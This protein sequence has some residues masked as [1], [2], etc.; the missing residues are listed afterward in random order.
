MRH[1]VPGSCLQL[2]EWPRKRVCQST[3][4]C[5][6]MTVRPRPRLF[7]GLSCFGK[8]GASLSIY[9]ALWST[10]RVDGACLGRWVKI[11][12]RSCLSRLY[13]R[14]WASPSH[15]A[16]PGS[17]G[18]EN[19]GRACS[20]SLLYSSHHT[21][22][23]LKGGPSRGAVFAMRPSSTLLP[24]VSQNEEMRAHFYLVMTLGP[25]RARERR[26]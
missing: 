22:I 1:K 9:S 17:E 24:H 21:P 18:Q 15:K 25:R 26:L 4:W 7:L 20:H 19:Q 12:R 5:R 16:R 13:R 2:G 23:P 8:R 6:E 14:P 10:L 3:Y 11:L